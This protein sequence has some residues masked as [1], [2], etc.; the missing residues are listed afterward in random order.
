ME[1]VQVKFEMGNVNPRG[2]EFDHH[3]TVAHKDAF[4][5]KMASVQYL[6]WLL[7]TDNKSDNVALDMN[8]T[9]HLDDFV[10]NAVAFAEKENKLRNLYK[11]ACVVSVLDSCGP[12]GYKLIQKKEKGIIDTVYGKY[13]E[14][15]DQMAKEKGVEKWNLP[16]TDKIEASKVAG[17]SLVSF[18]EVD[19]YEDAK[20]WIP[21]EGTYIITAEKNG[22]VLVE[23]ISE[24][25]NPLRASAY[26]YAKGYKAVVGFKKHAKIEGMFDYEACVRSN[27]D[28][29][30]SELWPRLASEEEIPAGERNWG[31][32]AGAGGSPRK[33]DKTGFLGGSTKLPEYILDLASE[34]V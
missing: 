19:D 27:Y 26:F 28:A 5:A 32:H 14:T 33:N 29:D 17:A 11:F 6:E 15:L 1:K 24:K 20:P 13:H 25:F 12:S 21:E 2:L 9:G 10:V 23:G 3:G 16:L 31:G 30:L 18:L 34:C 7:M 8:H 22:V 4:V